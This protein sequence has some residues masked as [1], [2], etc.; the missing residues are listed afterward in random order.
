MPHDYGTRRTWNAGRLKTDQTGVLEGYQRCSKIVTPGCK[1]LGGIHPLS[2][3]PIN[4]QAVILNRPTKHRPCCRPCT[5]FLSKLSKTQNKNAVEQGK[6]YSRER[7][8]KLA[9]KR[10]LKKGF[11]VLWDPS[12]VF[13]RGAIFGRTDFDNTLK[14][15]VWPDGMFVR[16]LPDN[17]CYQ[18]QL[19]E[20][21]EAED[22]NWF[23]F[24]K[25]Q[26]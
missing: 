26:I 6:I 9:S 12:R 23:E 17:Q 5:N 18:V 20:K 1:E 22:R 21:I 8:R 24:T 4:K 2:E 14:A 7:E 11:Q 13:V 3:Y 15:G 25:E 16:S 10:A 19:T